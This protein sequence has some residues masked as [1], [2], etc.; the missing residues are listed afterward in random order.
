LFHKNYPKIFPTSENKLDEFELSKWL[1]LS[2]IASKMNGG[3]N[4]F[5]YGQYPDS[6]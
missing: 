5:S 1:K 4:W 6:A 2:Y 3:H